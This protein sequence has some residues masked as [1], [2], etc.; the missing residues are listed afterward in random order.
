ALLLGVRIKKNA[1]FLKQQPWQ[2][3]SKQLSLDAFAVISEWYHYAILELTVI[4][5]FIC[6]PSTISRA[7]GISIAESK[8][9]IDRLKRLN[10]LTERDGHLVR[11]EKNLT[12]EHTRGAT[13]A[14]H[15]TLQRSILQMALDAIDNTPQEEKDITSITMAIDETKLPEAKEMI[16]KF[17]NHVSQFL[18]TDKQTRVYH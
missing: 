17:R 7:L 2:D 18:E 13:S 6:S 11:T 3:N 16:R 1:G 8:S 15:K 9:A 14:A 4:E 5:N 12:N 10:L